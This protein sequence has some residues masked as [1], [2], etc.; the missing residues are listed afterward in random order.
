MDDYERIASATRASQRKTHVTCS[1]VFDWWMQL[2]HCIGDTEV[3]RTE[4]MIRSDFSHAR[5]GTEQTH[6]E[7]ISEDLFWPALMLS[8]R[9]S[10]FFIPRVAKVSERIAQLKSA[11]ENTRG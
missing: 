8:I 5:F 10:S 9:H 11:E 1:G 3:D 4:V 7:T 2:C 6:I